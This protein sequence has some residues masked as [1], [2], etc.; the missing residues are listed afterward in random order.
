ME[1]NERDESEM[2]NILFWRCIQIVQ[3]SLISDSH[4]KYRMWTGFRDQET[5][6][7]PLT[8]ACG[9]VQD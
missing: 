3:G 6:E 5:N 1:R 2:R 7:A 4:S 9:Q 8:A